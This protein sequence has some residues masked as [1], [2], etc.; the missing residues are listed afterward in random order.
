MFTRLFR[1]FSD[2][3]LALV[4]EKRFPKLLGDRLI[5]AVELSDPDKAAQYG[6]SRAMV[7]ETIAE[8]ADRVGELPLGQVFDWKRL[9]RRGVVLAIITVVGYLVAVTGY[10]LYARLADQRGGLIGV[11]RLNDV[12][13]ILFERNILLQNTIWPRRSHLEVLEP[14][15]E[16]Y[17]VGRD[18]AAPVIRVRAYS[19]VIADRAKPAR[20]AGP[21]SKGLERPIRPGGAVAATSICR[22][23]TGTPVTT[24]SG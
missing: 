11:H 14:A 9:R 10:G 3:A 24:G 2:T 8:A 5:T 7:R 23:A 17:R 20:L 19:Y 16:D 13:A 15:T 1:E 6:Y 12:A 4:L 22:R 21:D 18:A